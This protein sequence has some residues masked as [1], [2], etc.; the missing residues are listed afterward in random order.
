VGRR[1]G[2]GGGIVIVLFFSI[3]PRAFGRPHLGR[4][5]GSAQAITVLASAIGPLVLAWS[6]ERTGSYATVFYGLAAAIALTAAA[7]LLVSVPTPASAREPV[8]VE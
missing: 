2:I 1:H 6:V 7:A 4:I 8:T 3:W 5:Q